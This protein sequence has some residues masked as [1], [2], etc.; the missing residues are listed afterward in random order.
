LNTNGHN[1]S[2]S[3]HR[4]PESP[5]MDQEGTTF[6]RTLLILRR[7]GWIF[8]LA[9]AVTLSLATFLAFTQPRFYRSE[10]TIEVGPDRPLVSPDSIGDPMGG[11]ALLWENHFRTYVALLRQPG[12]MLKVLDAL[13]PD[14]A[15]IYRSSPDPVRKMTEDLEITTVP[16]TF[17]IR[18]TLDH[19]TPERGPEVVNKLVA[20]FIE[21]ANQR[22]R[23]LKSGALEILSKEAL[24]VI[25]QKVDEAEQSLQ[26]FHKR[27]GYGDLEEQYASLQ[28]SKRKLGERLSEVRLRRISLRNHPDSLAAAAERGAETGR[29]SAPAPMD[30]PMTLE[31]LATRRT[32]MEVELARQSVLLKDKHPVVLSLRRQLEVVKDLIRKAGQTANQWREREMAAVDLE[33]KDLIEEE[34]RLDR[35]MSE[36]RLRLA[37]YKKHQAE[38]AAATEL[39]NS[40]LKKQ[41]EVKATS[42]AGLTSVR[43]VDLAKVPTEHHRKLH[44]FLALGAVLGLLFGAA[45]I[46]IAEQVDD[47]VATPRQAEASLGLDLLT[48][49]PRM[50]S[51]AMAKSRP[52]V[53]EDE[54]MLAPLEPFR[55]LR[56]EV[57]TRLQRTPGANVVAILSTQYG[58]GR[59]TVAI[60]LARVLALEGRRVLLF[61]GDLRRPCL[62]SFLTNRNGPGL[63]DYWRGKVPLDRCLQPSRVPGVDVIGPGAEFEGAAEVPGSARFRKVWATLRANY[64]IIVVDTSPINAASEVAVIAAH[65]DASILVVEER[66]TGIRQALAAKRRLEN[67]RI[68]VLGLVVNRSLTRISRGPQPVRPPVN[69]Q[70]V[71]DDRNAFLEV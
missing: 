33:E 29:P 5:A 17:L 54:P 43:I 60:N 26:D 64:D 20:L 40:Y 46:L 62:K 53:P 55:R 70:K 41:G 32:E 31:A 48:A 47:R 9:G 4:A 52:L 34:G 37:Q 22:L 6:L 1:G 25:R 23:E 63:E 3:E 68:S 69:A 44:V 28:E 18:I 42:G 57:V 56:T 36:A 65:A 11:E 19:P 38:V 21:D 71:S 14:T 45:G 50:A 49:I 30:G 66:R 16:S 10:A 35:Q 15:A 67:H 27:M 12:L 7:R 61:D 2:S 51:P 13:P 39:Y 58:E 8:V 59:S 24:P